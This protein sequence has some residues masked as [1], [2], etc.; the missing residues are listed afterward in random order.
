MWGQLEARGQSGPM[1]AQQQTAMVEE[2]EEAEWLSITRM[3]QHLTLPMSAP[4]VGAEGL[5]HVLRTVVVPDR[6][7]NI[8]VQG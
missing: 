8:V 1:E 3:P 2:V 4:L 6:L 5:T 7:V